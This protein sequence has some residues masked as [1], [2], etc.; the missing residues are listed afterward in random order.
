MKSKGQTVLKDFPYSILSFIK[1]LAQSSYSFLI[2]PVTPLTLMPIDVMR[3]VFAV[4]LL[5]CFNDKQHF[6]VK[7]KKFQSC[8]V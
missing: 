6:F 7:L 1:T 4:C 8:W 5:V 3:A 2:F